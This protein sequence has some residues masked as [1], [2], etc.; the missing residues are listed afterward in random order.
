MARDLAHWRA[1]LDAARCGAGD[2][3]CCEVAVCCS[4][5]CTVAASYTSSVCWAVYC[6]V[7]AVPL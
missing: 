6:A 2:A 7:A 3:V 4:V 5:C 1:L